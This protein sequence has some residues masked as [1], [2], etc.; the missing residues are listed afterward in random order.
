MLTASRRAGQASLGQDRAGSHAPVAS[1]TVTAPA[2]RSRDSRRWSQRRVSAGGHGTDILLGNF[3]VSEEDGSGG[4]IRT[5]DQRINSPLRYRCATP[6]YRHHTVRE[7]AVCFPSAADLANQM[8]QRPAVG[9]HITGGSGGCKPL[10]RDSR[11]SR[12][13]KG[14]CSLGARSAMEHPSRSR[15]ALDGLVAEWLRRG[16]QIL[17]PRFDSGR[18]LQILI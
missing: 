5:Y 17:A 8:P 9:R 1:V 4:R 16:L 6:E 12:P 10:D 14:R 2:P 15:H 13:K 18:G 3:I 11:E 7:S